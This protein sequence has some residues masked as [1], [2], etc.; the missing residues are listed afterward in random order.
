MWHYSCDAGCESGICWRNGVY[1]GKGCMVCGHIHRVCNSGIPDAFYLVRPGT[2]L[3]DVCQAFIEDCGLFP[4]AWCHIQVTL[5]RSA[6][7]LPLKRH[8]GA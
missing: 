3:L 8:Y 7:S 1:S 6:W 2:G 4:R 5:H